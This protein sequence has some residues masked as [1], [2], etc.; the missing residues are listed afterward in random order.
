MSK[1]NERSRKKMRGERAEEKGV[2]EIKDKKS[3]E[4]ERR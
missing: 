4:E 3:V 2:K 1:G